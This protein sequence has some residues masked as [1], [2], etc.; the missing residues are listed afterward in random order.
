MKK[1]MKEKGEG[2]H[3]SKRIG[4]LLQAIQFLYIFKHHA[5]VEDH[6]ALSS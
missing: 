2:V 3:A 5:G 6:G 1:E 4:S